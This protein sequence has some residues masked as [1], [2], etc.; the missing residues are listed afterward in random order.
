MVSPEAEAIR[1][2]VNQVFHATF[3]PTAPLETRR[4][5]Y[6]ALMSRG[7]LPPNVQ[8][9]AVTAGTRPA[10]W[11]SAAGAASEKVLLYLH[12]GGYQLGSCQAYRLLAATLSQVIGWRLLVLDYRLAPE[13]PFPA[14]V[15]DATAAYSWLLATGIKPEQIMLAG[16][17]AGGGLALATLISLRDAGAA[18]PAGALLFSPWTDL[19]LTGTSWQANEEQDFLVSRAFSLEQRQAYLGERDPRTP[20]ASPLY[21]DL[22]GLPP[23]LIQVGSEEVLLDD[24]TRLAE[25]AR[26][27]GVKVTLHIAEGMW[28]VWHMTA[29]V[30]L[31]PEGKAAFDQIADFVQR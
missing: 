15:E 19:A 17:S 1:T 23:L 5:Q 31:F 4:A 9:Q 25:R 7:H 3:Q 13:H 6:E 12:G 22:R 30:R 21:A 24:A 2:L 14:A 28:H 27:A 18:L 26:A 20:L 29:A 16:D 10:E 11:V 8:V